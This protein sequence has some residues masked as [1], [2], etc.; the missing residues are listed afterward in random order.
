MPPLTATQVFWQTARMGLFGAT[1][2]SIKKALSD[3]IKRKTR[4]KSWVVALLVGAIVYQ[5]LN[6]I[7]DFVLFKIGKLKACSPVDNM[8][9]YDE[10][11]KQSNVAMVLCF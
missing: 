9:L 11:G 8:F 10:K 6:K 1:C 4:Y 2:Y 3:Y 7:W 5:L